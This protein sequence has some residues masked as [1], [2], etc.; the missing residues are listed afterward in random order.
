MSWNITTSHSKA[1]RL[2]QQGFTLIEMLLVILIISLL[3]ALLLPAIIQSREAARRAHCRNNLYQLSI[4]LTNYHATYGMLPPGCVNSTGPVRNIPIG[5]HMS[6]LVQI[7]PMLERGAIFTQLDFASDAYS[8]ANSRFSNAAIPVLKC[9]SDGDSTGAMALNSNYAGST[10]GH[11]VPID[12]DNTGLLFLN[13]SVMFR[14]IRDGASNTLMVGERRRNDVPMTD[15][16]WL[17]GTS[18]TL[19]NCGVPINAVVNGWVG[20]AIRRPDDSGESSESAPLLPELKTG[21]FS[22]HHAGGCH[23]A[24]ADG[25][26]LFVSES[27]TQSILS[28]LADRDDGN[29]LEEF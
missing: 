15:L 20:V 22:S 19:R 12:M 27:I 8:V 25:A 26:V 2:H 7:L 11:D 23:F 14:E 16:G 24:M 17:S 13:S 21:G 10:G 1:R 29:M 9:P 28:N 6:W 18:A 4:A 5:Y 3:V